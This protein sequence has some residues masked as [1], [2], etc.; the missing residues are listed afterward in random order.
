MRKIN[1]AL[2]VSGLLIVGTSRLS[3]QQTDTL[4]DLPNLLLPRFTAGIVKLKSGLV[5]KAILNY[6][7]VN[8]QM[9]FLQRK[10]TLVVDEP[11]KIDT[12][13][14]AN[15]IFVPFPK[16]FY[17]VLMKEGNVTLFK[18]HKAYVESPG[19]PVGYGAKSQTAA[20]NYVHQIYGPT[21]VIKLKL[22][23]DFKVTDDSQYWIRIGDK[24]SSFE[25]RKQLLKILKDKQ[26]E[27]EM[28]IAGNKTDFKKSEDVKNL[29]IHYISL[30]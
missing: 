9:V 2:F 26:K 23:D 5:N 15:R 8:Q 4:T 12:V 30:K 25:N 1:F 3:A 18:Q 17:E 13:F 24:M 11:E 27:L 28:F 6:D 22:P 10:L 21:G 7:L 20:P 29:I 19:M 14:L 16:G